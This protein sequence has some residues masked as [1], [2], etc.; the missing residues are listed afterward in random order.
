MC[1]PFTREGRG[2]RCLKER[3]STTT[4]GEEKK[5]KGLGGE[6]TMALWWAEGGSGA[7]SLD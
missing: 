6:K 3:S 2:W 4:M 5:R 7:G 1:K